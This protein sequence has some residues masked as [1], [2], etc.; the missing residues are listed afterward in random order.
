M[1]TIY[2]VEQGIRLVQVEVVKETHTYL[3]I[4]EWRSLIGKQHRMPSVLAKKK[5]PCFY[6]CSEAIEYMIRHAESV[7]RYHRHRI[8]EERQRV[9]MLRT[10]LKKA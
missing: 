10:E 9:A 2:I 6:D 4:G 7:I 1:A 3:W 8:A 5:H